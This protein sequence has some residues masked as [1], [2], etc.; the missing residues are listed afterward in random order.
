[1]SE[2]AWQRDYLRRQLG[3]AERAGRRDKEMAQLAAANFESISEGFALPA[4]SRREEKD[5]IFHD[6]HRRCLDTG[7][8]GEGDV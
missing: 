7:S 8:T 6:P 2:A 5:G 4:Q 1:M 3:M